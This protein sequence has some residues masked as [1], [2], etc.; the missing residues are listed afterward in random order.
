[1]KAGYRLHLIKN[2]YIRMQSHAFEFT[3]QKSPASHRS[4]ARGNIGSDQECICAT[5]MRLRARSSGSC[6]L[7]VDVAAGHFEQLPRFGGCG[8]GA[9]H[10]RS[11]ADSCGQSARMMTFSLLTCMKPPLVAMKLFDAVCERHL[12]QAGRQFGEQRRVA[13]QHSE[14]SLR[15][16]ERARP[17][18]LRK[19]ADAPASP[20]RA[21]KVAM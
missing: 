9:F 20:V 11:P 15:C 3:Q 18:P 4:R 21:G 6:T 2:N 8:A 10:D 12:D 13:G 14:T 17:A 19:T 1:M 16:R 7:G 5:R